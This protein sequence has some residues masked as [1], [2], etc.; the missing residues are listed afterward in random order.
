MSSGTQKESREAFQKTREAIPSTPVLV[1][2]NYSKQIQI[3]SFASKD[4][5]AL[6]GKI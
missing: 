6:Y 5:I 1:S 4:T 2:P 3:L